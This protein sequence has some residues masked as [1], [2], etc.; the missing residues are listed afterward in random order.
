MGRVADSADA[1]RAVM[2]ESDPTGHEWAT[3]R[4][5]AAL[6]R[7]L[8]GDL[9]GAEHEATAALALGRAHGATVAISVALATQGWIAHAT[10]RLDE[11]IELTR[12]AVATVGE[13][14]F[15]RHSPHFFLGIVLCSADR[16]DE[17]EEVF[18]QA[19]RLGEGTGSRVSTAVHHCGLALRRFHSG[20][21]DDAQAE[22]EAGLALAE[23][24]GTGLVVFFLQ[25]IVALLHHHHGDDGAAERAVAAAEAHAERSGPQFG[26]DWLIWAR[27]LVS[28]PVDP[29]RALIGLSN[30]WGLYSALGLVTHCQT[31][32]PDL[33][34]LAV[35]AGEADRARA[36][37]AEVDEVAERTGAAS[38]RGAALRCRGLL[39]A[40]AE[41]LA[42]AS[43]AYER[44]GRPFEAALAAE[45]AAVAHLAAGGADAARPLAVTSLDTFE[46]LGATAASDRATTAFRALS[47]RGRR[48]PRPRPTSGWASLTPTELRVVELAATGLTNRVI[49][50]RLF[51]SRRTVETHLAHVFT[52]L[53]LSSRTELAAEA[54]RRQLATTS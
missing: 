4:A 15:S 38:D 24:R 40:D 21:W 5:E 19:R 14:D 1:I 26:L 6:G 13:R 48:R 39:E 3:L 43:T 34:R 45:D 41:L 22:A 11:A 25:S 35:G 28:E 37:T 47:P 49:G 42:A 9:A 33:V 2:A 46:R 16:L 32:G 31:I 17:A 36:V 54:T 29:A 10:G 20:E 53:D 18:Q 23:E 30:G 44:A 50:E 12:A 27:A 7:L 8:S 52:K 51:V